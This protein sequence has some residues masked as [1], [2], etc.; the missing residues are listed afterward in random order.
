MSL[1]FVQHK[2]NPETCP[3]KDPEQGNQLLEHLSPL[4]AKS[5]GIKLLADAVLDGK[6]TFNLILEA[7]DEEQIKK[8]ME[9]FQQAG[10]VDIT[11]AS[12]CET[13]VARE[14]C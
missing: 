2:H 4:N 6:H 3:A 11:P 13:V 5:Y 1:Y 10:T 9:P 14:G 7:G 8:F 12:H